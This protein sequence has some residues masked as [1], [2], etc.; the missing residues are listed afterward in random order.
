LVP[1]FPFGYGLSYTTF[2]YDNLRLN[3]DSFGPE[4]EIVITLDVT[5][6]GSLAG[7]EIV[8]V[9]V[10]DVKCRLARPVQ[11]LKA[12]AKV[13]LAPGETETVSLTLDRQSLAFYDP[14]VADWVTEAGEFEVRIGASSRDI[15]GKIP[16]NWLGDAGAEDNLHIGMALESL[17]ATEKG[18]A[19]LQEHLGADLLSHP[20]IEMAMTMTLEQIAQ[21]AGD[22]ITS[23]TLSAIDKALKA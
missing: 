20:M 3:G 12:F 6:N 19:V 7:Q 22:Q 1:L 5:N 2:A 10:S 4:D 23:E 13:K 8:Q 18:T 16:F 9:Y 15:R 14:I 11:E 17:L 21:F